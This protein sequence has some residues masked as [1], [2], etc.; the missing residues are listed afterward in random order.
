MRNWPFGRCGT[1]RRSC[2][3]GRRNRAHQQ[4]DRGR[5]R[6]RRGDARVQPRALRVRRRRDLSV[7]A[8]SAR[9]FSMDM[10]NTRSTARDGCLF[11]ESTRRSR[12]RT[13]TVVPAAVRRRCVPH[14]KARPFLQVSNLSCFGGACARA[15]A[16]VRDRKVADREDAAI[17]SKNQNNA[18][19]NP[20]KPERDA[21]DPR[22]VSENS[23]TLFDTN[24]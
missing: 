21:F 17:L 12:N 1:H 13:R 24:A 4:R 5:R 10:G 18:S 14:S 8:K 11:P 3:S 2:E 20:H 6:R 9:V 15:L 16:P 23:Q 19:W 22:V 7:V